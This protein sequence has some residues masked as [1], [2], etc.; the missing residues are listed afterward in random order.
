MKYTL[1]KGIAVLLF[2]MTATLI[3]R[4]QPGKFNQFYMLSVKSKLSSQWQ[5]TTLAQYRAYEGD[6][7][8]TRLFLVN[9]YLDYKLKNAPVQF[10]GGYMFLKIM[11]FNAAGEKFS[12]PEHRVFQQVSIAHKLSEH[13]NLSQRFRFEERFLF[14]DRFI[15]RARH[16]LTATY[17]LGDA[18]SSKWSLIAKEEIRMNLKKEEAFDSFRLW[19]GVGYKISPSLEIEP[20]WMTQFETLGASHFAVLS[21]RKSFDFSKKQ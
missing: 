4:A 21:V 16:M 5:L 9:T 3:G 13:F 1:C 15:I 2:L 11:P 7:T 6:I 19:G 17:K 20:Y 18:E 8:N 14:S 12:L 10:G